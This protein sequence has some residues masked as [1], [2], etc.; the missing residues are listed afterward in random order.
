MEL[1]YAARGITSGYVHGGRP[2]VKSIELSKALRLFY[3]LLL[4]TQAKFTRGSKNK[5]VLGI[6]I[7]RFMVYYDR[8]IVVRL[9][10]AGRLEFL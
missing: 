10:A 3:N 6:F 7:F 1:H 2:G 4:L 8:S 9:R 5:Y